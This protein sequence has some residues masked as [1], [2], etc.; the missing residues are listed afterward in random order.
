M[1][2]VTKINQKQ[3]YNKQNLI[4]EKKAISS[5]NDRFVIFKFSNLINETDGI[6]LPGIECVCATC[7]VQ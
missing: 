5:L 1:C 7:S 3:I 6:T 2:K 4:I